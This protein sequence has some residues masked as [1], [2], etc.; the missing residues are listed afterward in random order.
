M[1]HNDSELVECW[2]RGDPGAF[3]AIVRRWETP[4]GRFLSRMVGNA[5]DA[6]DLA[7]EVF[8]RVHQARENY[9][10]NGAFQVWLYRI[11]LN[12]VRDA[13]RRNRRTPNPIEDCD[14][15]FQQ[16]SPEAESQHKELTDAVE[17]AIASLPDTLREVL[18]LRHYEEMSFAEMSRLLKT[19]ESTLKSRFSLALLRVRD[20]LR[21]RGFL[22]EDHHE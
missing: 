17:R 16:D 14:K 4:M 9:R 15:E 11:A 2:Q 22:F 6:K 7:Q 18:V 20:R 13:A 21:E 3:E 12:A 8:L 19:P 5:E 10:E 1:P